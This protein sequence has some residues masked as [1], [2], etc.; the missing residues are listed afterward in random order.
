MSLPGPVQVIHY[1]GGS[2]PW[3][4]RHFWH[5]LVAGGTSYRDSRYFTYRYRLDTEGSHG[6]YFHQA[7]SAIMK[8]APL[9]LRILR[10]TDRFCREMFSRS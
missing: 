4:A 1:S 3:N 2:K 9:L 6:H 10:R 5:A 8:R 7:F